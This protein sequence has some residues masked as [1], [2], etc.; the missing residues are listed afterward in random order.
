MYRSSPSASL[1]TRY[2]TVGARRIPATAGSLG[3]DG[4]GERVRGQAFDRCREP[5]QL[6]RAVVGQGDDIGH[7]RLAGGDGA[8]LVHGHRDHRA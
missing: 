1:D 5:E 6:V 2:A 4:L 8:G 7:R 3:E